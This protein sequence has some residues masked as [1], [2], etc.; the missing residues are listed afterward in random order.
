MCIIYF[1]FY[2]NNSYSVN[3]YISWYTVNQG[4]ILSYQALALLQWGQ[5]AM[6]PHLCPVFSIVSMSWFTFA[7][8]SIILSCGPLTFTASNAQVIA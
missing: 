1:I 5:G 7:I 6:A 4:T 3:V 2:I 8:V